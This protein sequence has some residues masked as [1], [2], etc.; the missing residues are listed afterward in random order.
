MSERK[1]TGLLREG[2]TGA[3]GGSGE[4]L[5]DRLAEGMEGMAARL[6]E[7]EALERARRSGAF[8]QG[9]VLAAILALLALNLMAHVMSIKAARARAPIDRLR[10]DLVRITREDDPAGLNI[11]CIVYPCMELKKADRHEETGTEYRR[12]FISDEKLQ[13][14]FKLVPEVKE[15]D[16]KTG[17]RA[18]DPPPQT[19][20]GGGE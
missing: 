8:W 4:A 2:G 20:S 14:L 15:K 18:G 7:L 3:D 11:E 10:S 1:E 9:L 5:L 17:K 6:R 13:K 16:E 12:Y 19:S